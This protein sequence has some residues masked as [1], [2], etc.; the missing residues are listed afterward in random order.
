MKSYK[1][2]LDK[3]FNLYFLQLNHFDR[4]SYCHYMQRCIEKLELTD[5]IREI[6]QL[7]CK[8]SEKTYIEITDFISD[9]INS[10]YYNLERSL[11]LRDLLVKSVSGKD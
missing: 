5:C 11:E 6:I 7:L 1:Q 3:M 4:F 9:F 2:Q 8:A 10:Y